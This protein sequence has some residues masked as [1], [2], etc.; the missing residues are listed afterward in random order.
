MCA[1]ITGDDGPTFGRTFS[2]CFYFPSCHS[3]PLTLRSLLLGPL[4]PNIGFR[5]L[6]P[7]KLLTLT[8]SSPHPKATIKF[9]AVSSTGNPLPIDLCK[10]FLIGTYIFVRIRFF[11]LSWFS[12][13]TLWEIMGVL[14]KLPEFFRNQDVACPSR[15]E[16]NMLPPQPTQGD[17]PIKNPQHCRLLCPWASVVAFGVSDAEFCLKTE[18]KICNIIRFVC[19]KL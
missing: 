6:I 18:L 15:P 13:A 10:A 7:L 11:W 5:F 12:T 19:Y 1:E 3:T 2:L 14:T 8:F 17:V 16:K 4:T 9:W